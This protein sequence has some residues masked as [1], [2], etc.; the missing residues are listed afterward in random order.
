MFPWYTARPFSNSGVDRAHPTRQ[1]FPEKIDQVRLNQ[2]AGGRENVDVKTMP[3]ACQPS[4][5]FW[6]PVASTY[7]HASV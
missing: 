1:P 5:V 3:Y 2:V 7:H 4:S 6:A